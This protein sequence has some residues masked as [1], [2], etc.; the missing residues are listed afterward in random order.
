MITSNMNRFASVLSLALLYACGGPAALEPAPEG[1]PPAAPETAGAEVS[2]GELAEQATSDIAAS[3]DVGYGTVHFMER[4]N[5]DG[6]VLIGI[7]EQAPSGYATTPLQLMLAEGHTHLE[8]FMALAPD[9]TPP[10]AYL[11]AHATQA[12]ELG[13]ANADILP[14]FFDANAPI[15]KSTTYCKSI[16]TP[17]TLNG[18]TYTYSN[19]MARDDVRGNQSLT[20]NAGK[21]A[22]APAICN[23][24]ASNKTSSHTV[25]G[26]VRMKRNGGSYDNPGWN[27]KLPPGW[28]TRWHG[29]QLRD[30][31]HCS[32]WPHGGLCPDIEVDATYQLQGKSNTTSSVNT[33]DLYMARIDS[34]YYPVR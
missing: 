2:S 30:S 20:L 1:E 3:V 16:A 12:T 5:A 29:L 27:S 19:R 17:T 24:N 32:N 13:R 15:E 23:E 34:S 28:W 6:T 9:Q 18:W 7:G 25:Q 4:K 10:A 33:Y 14:A 21:K 8:V 22:V 31:S 11:D 26:R